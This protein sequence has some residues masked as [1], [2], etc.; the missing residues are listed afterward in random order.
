MENAL[1]SI[2]MPVYKTNGLFFKKAVESCLKQSF[3]SFELIII[4]DGSPDDCGTIAESYKQV[5]SRVIVVHQSNSGVSCARNKG[6]SIANGE[7]VIF[8]DAD[9]WIEPNT[10]E[11]LSSNISETHLDCYLFLLS[12]EYKTSSAPIETVYLDNQLFFQK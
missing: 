10:L 6:I 2:V 7:Y 5:D 3:C 8:I 1:F 12:R 9:D 11:I 4:D